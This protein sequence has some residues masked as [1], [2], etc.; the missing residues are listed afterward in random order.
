MFQEDETVNASN[1]FKE[2]QL[3]HPKRCILSKQVRQ[4]SSFQ[5]F[6]FYYFTL[7]TD[8][9]QNGHTKWNRIYCILR[10]SENKI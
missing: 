9:I 4:V 8:V 6:K 1:I 5:V 3:L 2:T 10:A 7:F